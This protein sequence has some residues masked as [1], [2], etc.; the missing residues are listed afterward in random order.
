MK[1]I[2]DKAKSTWD[3]LRKERDFHRLHHRR[4]V[5]EKNQL[6]MDMKR[7]KKHF[8]TYEPALE[9]LQQKYEVAV[10]DKTMVRLERDKLAH[11]LELAT[12]QLE[13]IKMEDTKPVVQKDKKETTQ[14]KKSREAPW[15]ENH[16]NPYENAEFEPAN[17]NSMLLQ[18]TFKGHSMAI[19]SYFI[20]ILNVFNN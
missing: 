8:S 12:M 7:L 3:K 4:V 9:A 16:Q 19:S 18:K 15:P 5:Q 11:R 17:I 13:E 10:K 6:I 20:F 2:A 14:V 1:E